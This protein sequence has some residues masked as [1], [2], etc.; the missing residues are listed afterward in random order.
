M[1][2]RNDIEC[3][4]Q[5][6]YQHM[7]KCNSKKYVQCTYNDYVCTYLVHAQNTFVPQAL[8][9]SRVQTDLT[10]HPEK[11]VELPRGK[12]E[13]KKMF[14]T[15]MYH[16]V[17]KNLLYNTKVKAFPDVLCIVVLSVIFTVHCINCEQAR[18]NSPRHHP[19]PLLSKLYNF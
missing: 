15:Y 16:S 19:V 11:R 18:I 3:R 4:A 14:Y 5:I 7:Q 1:S 8:R 12:S 6:T 13:Q 2:Y 10:I 9:S 17:L